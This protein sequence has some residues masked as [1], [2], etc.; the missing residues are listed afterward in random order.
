ML[1]LVLFLAK[2]NYEIWKSEIMNK[3]E[4]SFFIPTNLTFF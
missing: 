4:T 3:N 1:I 2:P